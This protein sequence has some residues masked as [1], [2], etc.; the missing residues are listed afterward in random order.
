MLAS[1]CCWRGESLDYPRVSVS[2]IPHPTSST[3]SR[4]SKLFGCH[5][6]GR[7]VFLASS[8]Q[9]CCGHSVVHRRPHMTIVQPKCP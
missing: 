7:E 9:E 8:G 4:V 2:P 6:R 5:N 1:C 3:G